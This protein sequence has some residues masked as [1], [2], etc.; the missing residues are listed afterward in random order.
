MEIAGGVAD[1]SVDAEDTTEEVQIKE[2]IGSGESDHQL[3]N[4]RCFAPQVYF[5]YHS[6][7]SIS[8]LIGD[9]CMSFS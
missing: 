1:S 5:T 9:N 8:L 7:I 2:V 3:A 4:R 6:S